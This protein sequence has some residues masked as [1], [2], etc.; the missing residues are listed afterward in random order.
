MNDMKNMLLLTLGLLLW[1]CCNLIS[2]AGRTTSELDDLIKVFEQNPANSQTTIQLLRELDKAGKPCQEVIDRYFL[3]QQEADYCKECNWIIVRDFVTDIHSPQLRYVFEHQEQFIRNFSKDDVLQK[4]DNVLVAHLDKLYWQDKADYE[5]TL[6]RIKDNGYEHYDVVYDYFNIRSLRASK[7][8]E[9]YFY[10]ARKLF[11]YFP[12]NRQMIKEI[13]AG[14]LEIMSDISRLKVIQLWA[15]KTVES[16]SDF[17]AI[18]N[19]VKISRKCGFN[20]VARKYAEIASR[21]AEKS[22]NPSMKRQA[23]ELQRL[24]N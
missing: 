3:T 2:A 17:D 5:T 9:D 13:T 1:S 14:A 7:N 18:Y 21:M 20:D 23:G 24:L 19:Y 16:K 11:R 15:G 6:R 10:K 22:D 8:A 4:L 12:E